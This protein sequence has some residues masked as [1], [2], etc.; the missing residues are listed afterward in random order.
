MQAVTVNATPETLVT[1]IMVMS[2]VCASKS[3][4]RR[5]IEGGG[6]KIGDSK[7]DNVYGKVCDYTSENDFVLN[8]GKK[9]R[10]KIVLA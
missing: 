6:V 10:L 1:D 8:K 9:T 4:A 5:L 7:V 3:E 2:K